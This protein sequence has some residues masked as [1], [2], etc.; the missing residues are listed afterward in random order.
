MH[1]ARAAVLSAHL[2]LP[3]DGSAIQNIRLASVAVTAAR[4][5]VHA[6]V[7]HLYLE[8]VAA[9]FGGLRR[10]VAKK[11]KFVLFT[12]DALQAPKRSLVLKMVKPPVPSA[13]AARICWLVAVDSG[14]CGTMERGWFMGLLRPLI[15]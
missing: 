13:R 1:T 4:A 8:S 3:F 9:A 15:G 2:K 6:A 7:I 11:I 14:N 10:N 5:H 12:G